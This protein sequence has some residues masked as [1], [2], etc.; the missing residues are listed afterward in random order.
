MTTTGTLPVEGPG[1]LADCALQRI[2]TH[3]LSNVI[4]NLEQLIGQLTVLGNTAAAQ[5]GLAQVIDLHRFA[6]W[7]ELVLMEHTAGY[8]D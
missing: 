2:D 3:A 4:A 5:K 8:P 6:D 1:F 7:V